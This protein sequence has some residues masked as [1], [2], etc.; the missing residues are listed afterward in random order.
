MY[1]EGTPAKRGEGGRRALAH[2]MPVIPSAD[3]WG[4]PDEAITCLQ[5]VPNPQIAGQ[6]SPQREGPLVSRE[7]EAVLAE[8]SHKQQI[9]SSQSAH[10][11]HGTIDLLVPMDMSPSYYFCWQHGCN[12]RAFTNLSN[13]RRHCKEKSESYRKPVCPRCGRQFVREAARDSHYGQKRCKVV[14]ID[15]N[16][17]AMW[18]SVQSIEATEEH[19][20]AS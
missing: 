12:G 14:A 6:Q 17:A 1:A 19:A 2:S 3:G 4:L 20:K 8:E 7:L 15:A 11:P 5:D 18:S 16:G 10:G 13:Y 9:L